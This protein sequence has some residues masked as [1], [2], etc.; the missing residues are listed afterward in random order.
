[1]NHPG[2]AIIY[3]QS[4]LTH[5][6]LS[7][8][9]ESSC[10]L[11]AEPFGGERVASL[12]RTLHSH[13]DASDPVDWILGAGSSGRG[14]GQSLDAM[15]CA[16]AMRRDESSGGRRGDSR[17]ESEGDSSGAFAQTGCDGCDD[18]VENAQLSVQMTG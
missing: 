4:G 16:K 7:R 10:D 6:W 12:V 1:M 2:A 3:N 8:W 15:S 5:L 13:N 11:D 14:G 17:D 18:R 9:S